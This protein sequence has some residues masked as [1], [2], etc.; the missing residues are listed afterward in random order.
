MSWM[1][2]SW[3]PE[4]STAAG[5]ESI[6]LH[7]SRVPMSC[8]DAIL[9]DLSLVVLASTCKGSG[10]MFAVSMEWVTLLLFLP[11]HLVLGRPCWGW[12]FTATFK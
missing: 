5:W 1:V 8:S 10:V 3:V 9:D 2:A 6:S 7:I 11:K 4:K 12:T